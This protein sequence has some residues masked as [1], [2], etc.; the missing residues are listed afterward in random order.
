M[1]VKTTKTLPSKGTR[2]GWMPLSNAKHVSITPV[3]LRGKRISAQKV[4][5]ITDNETRR[6]FIIP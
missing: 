4:S 3:M 5:T 1:A 6:Y 2:L